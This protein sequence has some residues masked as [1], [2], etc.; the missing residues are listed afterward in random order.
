MNQSTQRATVNDQPRNE[1]SKLRRREEVDFEHGHRMGADG[2]VPDSVNAKLGKLP[3]DALPQCHGKLA[4]CRVIL[5]CARL[6]FQRFVFTLRRLLI[7]ACV[8]KPIATRSDRTQPTKKRRN[9][10]HKNEPARCRGTVP[11]RSI[12]V[13]RSLDSSACSCQCT[14]HQFEL[15]RSG[16]TEEQGTKWVDET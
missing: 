15:F 3:P 8:V 6:K 10:K 13:C 9:G 4:L 16:A 5:P 14:I 2:P 7:N 1:S 12:Y 11:G